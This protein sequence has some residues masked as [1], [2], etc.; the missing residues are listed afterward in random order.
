MPTNG[1]E[2]KLAIRIAGV[3]DKTYDLALTG[4]GTKLKAFTKQ[5]GKIDSY[6]KEMDKGYKAIM[7]VGKKCFD[8]IAKAAEVAALAIGSVTAAAVK[9]GSDFEAEMSVVQA[10]SQ[11]TDKDLDALAK[12]AREVGKTSVFSATEVGKAMEYMGM[13]GWK[14]EE[15]LAGIQG[16]VDLAAASGED[17]ATVS[18]IVVDTLTAMGR[19]ADDTS[20]FVDVLAQAAMN[21]NTNVEL[22]GETF[23]YAAP[24]AGALGYNFKD[25]AIA[26]GLMASSGI[27]G[28]LAGTAL[29]NMLTRMAKPTKESRDA[30]EKL[31]LSLEDEEGKAYSLMDI[32]LKLRSSFAESTD[33]EGMAAALTSLGG[34]TDEQIEEYQSGL[35]DLSTAEEAFLAAELGGLRGMSGLLAL[36]NSSDEQFQQLAQSIYGADGAVGKMASVRLNNLQGDLTILKDAARDAGIEFYYQFNDDLR[37]LVQLATE[38]VN[39]AALKIPEFFNNLKETFP[40]LQRYFKRYALPVFEWLFDVGKWFVKNGRTIISILAGIGATLVVYKVAS[41]LSHI[42][43]SFLKI[44]SLGPVGGI[45]LGIAGAISVLA[46]TIVN[47]KLKEREL[48]DQSLADH[49]GDIALSMEDLSKVADY[50]IQ[51]DN[52]GKVKEALEAFNDLDTY[53]SSIEEALKEINKLNWKVSIGMEL[54]PEDKEAYENAIQ[55]FTSN[56]QDYIIQQNYAVDISLSAFL[57]PTSQNDREFKTKVD[58]FYQTNLTTL[59]ELGQDLADAVNKGF[60]DGFKLDDVK[61]VAKIQEQMAEI[62]RQL[63]VDDYNVALTKL[64]A[65]FSGAALD[66]NS[67]LNLQSKLEEATTTATDAYFETYAKTQTALDKLFGAGGIS[68][69]EYEDMS[70]RNKA[71]METGIAETNLKALEFQLNTIYDTYGEDISKYMEVVDRLTGEYAGKFEEYITNYDPEAAVSLWNSLIQEIYGDENVS[72]YD[73]GALEELILG[74]GSQIDAIDRIESQLKDSLANVSD[75][76]TVDNIIKLLDRIEEF[77]SKV[78]PAQEASSRNIWFGSSEFENVLFGDITNK[79]LSGTDNEALKSWLDQNY[80]NLTGTAYTE[81]QAAADRVA[82]DTQTLINNAFS[83]GFTAEADVNVFLSPGMIITPGLSMSEVMNSGLSLEMKNSLIH[84]INGHADG[85]FVWNRELSWLGEEGPEAV[86]PLDGSDRAASLW[87]KAGKLLGMQS[88]SERYDLSG[89]AAGSGAKIEYSPT[90]QFYGDAPSRQD[91]D[92]ALRMSQDEFEAMMERYLKHN[93]R[94]AFR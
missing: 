59:Q 5:F 37:G 38:F 20:E 41:T 88:I 74:M 42:V 32:M 4:A 77:R 58:T 28:S 34:L 92:D 72:R 35:G 91:L 17:M 54:T 40:T 6:F 29:R 62:Q 50:I 36:A 67:F 75:K 68:K 8:V 22:M 82:Q 61:T 89:A 76:Q 52:L 64:G 2:Y 24:V 87:E 60:E 81:A 48:I 16:V 73:G 86:I 19:T 63:A 31:G 71:S 25:L 23:K 79:L 1:K 10:I 47:Y 85:G 53:S 49:F 69:S 78:T 80:E 7:K 21:S 39:S 46:G 45:L 33:P 66:S 3:V 11:A 70:A 44:L 57:D 84:K 9:V 51:T 13:A 65:E 14:S 94:V 43:M 15:M 55:S 30:M 26:T 83:K 18:S 90:L 27:K 12:K 56:V 93:G